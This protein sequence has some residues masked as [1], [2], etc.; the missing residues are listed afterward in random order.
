MKPHLTAMLIFWDEAPG[1]LRA[2]AK[3]VGQL[4][5][6]IVA[7]DGPFADFDHARVSSRPEAIRALELGA[8]EAKTELEV[9]P[10][11][12][13]E[14]QRAKRDFLLKR[15][16]EL[17][18]DWLFWSD[19]DELI[20]E[21]DPQAVK[22]ELAASD[23]EVFR[24]WRYTPPNPKARWRPDATA[25]EAPDHNLLL[26]RIFRA[27]DEMEIV[28]V[29]WLYRG[30][31]SGGTEA[32]VAFVVGAA[33]M[34]AWFR[35]FDQPANRAELLAP[36]LFEHRQTWRSDGYRKRMLAYRKRVWAAQEA[37]REP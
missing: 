14:G 19:A 24:A 26:S 22:A 33:Q 36:L 23:A 11:R 27:L 6:R 18:T 31:R 1:R 28:G 4:A 20:T 30:R 21:C 35:E 37:G 5:D 13:W 2:W 8:K 34:P 32:R 16:V 29:H 3:S 7:A 9:I 15:C 25:D 12:T 10:G 17:G